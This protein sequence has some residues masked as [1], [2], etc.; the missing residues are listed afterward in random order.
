[1]KQEL[2]D[3]VG[4][5]VLQEE[6]FNRLTQDEWFQVLH[7]LNAHEIN[8]MSGRFRGYAL[9]QLQTNNTTR[10]FLSG[11]LYD[12]LQENNVKLPIR[13][14]SSLLPEQEID[15]C[16]KV[17]YVHTDLELN[18]DLVNISEDDEVKWDIQ[19]KEAA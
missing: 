8:G 11:L 18:Y 1:M 6:P 16:R 5:E 4:D 12:Y 10:S 9:A 15:L 13:W 14:S 19:R 7:H 2:Y 3:I 17:A